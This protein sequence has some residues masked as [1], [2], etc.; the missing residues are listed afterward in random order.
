L[1]VAVVVI[2]AVISEMA[3]V[4]SVQIGGTR[5]YDGPMGKSDRAFVFGLLALLLGLGVQCGPWVN[6][7][8]AVVGALVAVTIFNRARGALREHKSSAA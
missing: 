3:G 7:Y 2:L 4:V 8:L 6:I 5:R 1:L